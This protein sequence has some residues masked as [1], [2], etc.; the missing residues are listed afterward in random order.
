MTE[1]QA[2]LGLATTEELLR[3]IKVRMEMT[4]PEDDPFA[5]AIAINSKMGLDA[6]QLKTLAYRTVES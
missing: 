3:E 2:N 4:S 6:L 5:M 1:E